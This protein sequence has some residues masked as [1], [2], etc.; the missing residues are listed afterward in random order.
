MSRY[1]GITVDAKRR[2]ALP[3]MFRHELNKAEAA[4]GTWAFYIGYEEDGCLYLLTPDQY[5]AYATELDR[6][7]DDG[8]PDDR[9]T[10][11]QI[12]GNFQRVHTDNAN[13]LTIPEEHAEIA[14]LSGKIDLVSGDRRSEIWQSDAL[15]RRRE[16]GQ[17]SALER[18]ADRRA[19]TA[20]TRSLTMGS[21]GE[22]S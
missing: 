18:L 21:A 17:Q 1:A 6:L 15:R 3:Q 16:D 20:T 4:D 2:W 10:R 13:R 9:A 14:G 7:F 19:Q 22:G 12:L 8:D 11:T 5:D